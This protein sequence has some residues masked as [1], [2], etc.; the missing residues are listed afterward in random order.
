[1]SGNKKEIYA[2]ISQCN[3]WYGKFSIQQ[4]MNEKGWIVFQVGK[5]LV[6]DVSNHRQLDYLFNSVFGLTS[7]KT[8]KLGMASLALCEENQEWPVDSP[9]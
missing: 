8:S 2:S 1:M 4:N 6:H 3:M 5:A 9:H 7:R